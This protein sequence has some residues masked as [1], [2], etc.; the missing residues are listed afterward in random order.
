MNPPS[1]PSHFQFTNG[2]PTDAES[3][4]GPL[5]KEKRTSQQLRPAKYVKVVDLATLN[6]LDVD[7]IKSETSKR[8]EQMEKDT[9]SKVPATPPETLKQGFCGSS[10]D[11]DEKKESIQTDD[12]SISSTDGQKEN[13]FLK[14]IMPCAVGFNLC[15]LVRNVQVVV[16]K[17]R[18]DKSKV[19]LAE[20]E[21]G[22]ETGIVSLRARDEQISLLQDICRQKGAAVL[23]NCSIE[24][25]QGKY[26]RLAVSKWGKIA[27]HP[28]GVSSTPPAPTQMND[29]LHLSMTGIFDMFGKDWFESLPKP[30]LAGRDNFASRKDGAATRNRAKPDR[31]HSP[32]PHN[33]TS[34]HPGLVAGYDAGLTHAQIMNAY[35]RHVYESNMNAASYGF[36]HMQQSYLPH[37]QQHFDHYVAQD[38]YMRYPQY[39][40]HLPTEAMAPLSYQQHPYPR[41]MQDVYT[42]SIQDHKIYP[43]P[44]FFH[45]RQNHGY[46]HA[47]QGGHA[48]NSPQAKHSEGKNVTLEATS[49]SVPAP[50]LSPDYLTSRAQADDAM[51]S[52]RL[53]AKSP[54]MNP[55]AAV[56]TSSSSGYNIPSLMLPSQNYFTDANYSSLN[57]PTY[58]LS[59]NIPQHISINYGQKN[60]ETKTDMQVP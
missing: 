24:L 11:S 53:E 33:T 27:M 7:K 46:G 29:Q 32:Y 48:S 43:P 14:R 2:L 15:L 44:H 1:S 54:M 5:A 39:T 21:V 30:D 18:V 35:S 34:Y 13:Q 59:T 22:D 55:N 40:A 52:L 31:Y 10:H 19:R 56:F 8:K 50:H 49:S 28:D 3:L 51:W 16:E 36:G 4:T 23:R 47:N 6:Q 41:S 60:P 25:Y 12:P 37:H 57:N 17:V 45:Q 26:I 20:C 58:N 38:A 9:E 42:G